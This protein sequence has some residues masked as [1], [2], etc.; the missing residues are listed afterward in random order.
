MDP[1]LLLI[2]GFLVAIL[3][4]RAAFGV[5]KKYRINPDPE[6]EAPEAVEAPPQKRRA[7]YGAARARTRGKAK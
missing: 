2:L 6:P 5:R 3:A 1:G 4:V 7:S